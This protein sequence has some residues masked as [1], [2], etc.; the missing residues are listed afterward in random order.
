MRQ[1][2]VLYVHAT[3]AF[4]GASKSLCELLLSFPEGSV[5]AFVLC[6]E[7]PAAERFT[8]AGAQVVTA[9]G[10][11]KWDHTLY[12]FYRG[13]RW[14]LLLREFFLLGPAWLAVRRARLRIGQVDLVHANDVTVLLTAAAAA[15]LFRAPLIVHV[16]SLQN[17]DVRLRRTRWQNALLRRTTS[18]VVAIDET[19]RRTL[20]E[21]LNV[22]VVHNGFRV[23]RD[24]AETDDGIS[25]RSR[26]FR[27]AIVGVLLRLKGVF[28]F[29]EAA[30]LCRLHGVHAEFWI[31]GDN[32]RKVEGL[33]GKVLQ[34]FGFAEDVRAALS[35]E[36]LAKGLQ[37]SVKLLGFI[38]DVQSIYRQIDVLCFPSHLDAAGRPVFEAAW[39]GVPS[40]VAARNPEPDTIV[41]GHSGLCIEEHN[42]TALA[43]AIMRLHVNAVERRKLGAG[44]R[45]LAETY[46]DP[47]LNASQ[48]LEIYRGEAHDSMTRG[49]SDRCHPS[50]R[51]SDSR[52][53]H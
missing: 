43:N 8:R 33:R 52:V 2:T 23:R 16:R 22:S 51:T 7:G 42:P 15:R 6:P 19:V 1:L 13:N 44:A 28:E 17:N 39:F 35:A 11:P 48:M 34:A 36:I 4:G 31:V 12:G 41:H 50:P 49:D 40:I 24:I 14:L 26:A 29:V 38:D 32:V 10:I 20:P 46:F 21:G 3:A 25:A 47:T 5:R 30:H 37:E 9:V 27:V 53:K 45:R 18:H